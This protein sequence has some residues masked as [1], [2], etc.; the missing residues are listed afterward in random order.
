[1]QTTDEK[2]NSVIMF[3]YCKRLDF[4]VVEIPMRILMTG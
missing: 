2:G 3:N 4:M 1:M